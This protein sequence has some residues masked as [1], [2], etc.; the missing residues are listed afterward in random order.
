M[1]KQYGED[2]SS[3]ELLCC[4]CGEEN[5]A[6]TQQVTYRKPPQYVCTNLLT[7]RN[8]LYPN[9]NYLTYSFLFKTLSLNYISHIK[10]LSTAIYC[11]FH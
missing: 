3:P 8:I 1:G 6:V 9:A 2:W 5:A 11:L 7:K 10:T 4:S